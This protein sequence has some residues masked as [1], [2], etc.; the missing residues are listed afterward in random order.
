M[1]DNQPDIIDLLAQSSAELAA[2]RRQRPDAVHNTQLSFHALLETE[3]SFTLA[4]RYHIAAYVAQL[5]PVATAREF[6]ADLSAEEE[7]SPRI[8]HARNFAQQLITAPALATQQ[9]LQELE[10]HFSKDELVSLAQL[11]AFLAYQLRLI[12]GLRILGGHENNKKFAPLE[13][14]LP[15][16]AATFVRHT[17]GWKP[18]I[19][20]LAA[21][22]M[23]NEQRE[24]LIKPERIHQPYFRLL[25]R[26]PAALQARTL[27]DLDI[28]YN[29][30][31]GLT[32]AEREL[33]A[34][35]TSRLNGC[36][37]CTSVHAARTLDEAP[38][39]TARI[40]ALLADAHADLSDPRWN[41]LSEAAR[42]ITVLNFDDSHVELLRTVGCDTA[43]IVDL[44][45]SAAFFN[46]A[47]RLMLSLG[48]EQVPQKLR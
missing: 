11:I 38:E 15:S 29:V 14:E 28:F 35:V 19:T 2:I 6:Y 31:G 9:Q 45:N 34:T 40:D 18:W 37:Y 33:A 44:I 39:H 4:E 41:A 46:W 20:P 17:L 26:D 30:D 23:T 8:A 12:H 7:P 10:Q 27:T 5:N 24:S 32:R 13:P 22:E 47:N 16:V 21:H 25:A 3:S 1:T 42:A 43:A 48:E 36:V